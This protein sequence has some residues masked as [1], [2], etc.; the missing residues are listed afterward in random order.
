M[1]RKA[2]TQEY[3]ILTTN[4]KGKLPM[5][6]STET[7]AGLVA[8]G[9]MDLLLEGAIKIE[10]KKVEAVAPLPGSLGHLEGLY[11]YLSDKSRSVTKVIEDYCMSFSSSRIN[12]LL[13]DTGN[14]LS[15]AGAVAEGKGGLVP[16]K[17]YKEAL[18]ET[19][20]RA[21]VQVE[22]L[23]LH[24]AALASLLKET[25]NLKPYFSKH[26]NDLMKEKLKAIKNQQDSKI[27]REMVGYIDAI[28]TV[29]MAAVIATVN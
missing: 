28:M 16:E 24:D 5:A 12:Q 22:S 29:M 8:A 10:G 17:A 1:E 27:I 3:L 2:L 19:L 21:A 25:R 18:I 23:S 6:N 26:E 11:A 4:D 14:S 15:A 7:K 20:K 9:I 13:T